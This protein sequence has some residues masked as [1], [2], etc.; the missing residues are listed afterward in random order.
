[1]IPLETSSFVPNEKYSTVFANE[2]TLIDRQLPSN[3]LII[4][5]FIEHI[6]RELEKMG[7]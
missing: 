3:H 1:M 5:K 6:F 2:N 7:E 4:H